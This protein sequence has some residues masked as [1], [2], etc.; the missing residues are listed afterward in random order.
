M[1]MAAPA[2][3]SKEPAIS[4]HPRDIYAQTTRHFL[5]PVIP[6]LDDPTVSE[7]LIN[8]ANTIYFERA[9][10]LNTFDGKFADEAALMA[11]ARNLAEYV[12]RTLDVDHHSMDGRLPDGSRVH[13]IL[14]PSSR[15]GVC[16]S[17]RKFQK[18]VYNI[19]TL[20]ERGSLSPAAAEFL[21]L[22]VLLKK[23]MVVAGGTGTGKTSMLNALSTAIPDTE[24]V[25]VIE[26]SSELQLHQPHTLYLEAQPARPGGRGAVSIRDLFVDSLRMRP[27]RILVGEVRRGEALD[28]I[29]SMLSGHT[30]SLTTVHASTPRDAAIRL[31]TL[32]QMSDV[33]LPQ[34]VA[35]M[36]VASAI[37][38]IVQLSRFPDGSRRVVKIAELMGLNAAGDYTLN[39]LFAFRSAGTGPDGMVLG[40]LEHTG[41]K[42]AFAAEV[43]EMGL[44]SRIVETAAL[45]Q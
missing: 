43:S 23:N 9:G 32:C 29:Q 28:L 37:Q 36:Q 33:G 25:I 24:R 27:D 2:P 21:Q 12:N 42:P 26:D 10:R 17:I 31:E 34:H 39:D 14:P 19:K 8:G 11:A 15:Q 41:A 1:S 13:V 16:I 45:F 5:H 40:K 35:R 22:A 44:T 38:V 3:A 4:L 20:I 7:I 6:L 30:G 18:S